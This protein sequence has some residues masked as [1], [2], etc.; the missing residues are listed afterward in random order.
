[1]VEV[2]PQYLGPLEAAAYAKGVP[3]SWIAAV[4][5]RTGW[6][7]YFEVLNTPSLRVRRLGITGLWAIL[8]D[9]IIR[10][11]DTG[12]A[13]T[14][15]T[16]PNTYCDKVYGGW[17][18]PSMIQGFPD[19]SEEVCGTC[20]PM[21]KWSAIDSYRSVS[22]NMMKAAEILANARQIS[23]TMC[24]G[25]SSIIFV[26]WMWGG[27]W[28]PWDPILGVPRCTLPPNIPNIF[29]QEIDKIIEAQKLFAEYFSEP[30]FGA[31]PVAVA[32]SANALTTSP[33]LPITFTANAAGGSK[34]YTYQWNF[35][36]G[37]VNVETTNPVIQHAFDLEG[38]YQVRCIVI[39]R[40]GE[41][42]QSEPLTITIEEGAPPPPAGTNWAL[43]GL[44]GLAGAVGLIALGK[45][46]DKR[47]QA[48]KLR[49]QASALRSQAAQLRAEG[50]HQQ[51]A[52]VEQRAT[53]LENKATQL[54]VEAAREEQEKA[55]RE[56]EKYRRV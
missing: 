22:A 30:D 6:D 43:W 49:Q 16:A 37:T 18:L 50:K 44:L 34:P 14:C 11:Q 48:R 13:G 12:M 51:A 38:T 26:R 55:R 39:D 32:I 15:F 24:G 54:E 20:G 10:V 25:D 29:V 45:K 56:A 7:P 3:R 36:D 21:F 42:G 46:G 19:G 40:V 9:V 2:P 47:E 5:E 52:A 33:G 27:Y 28:I 41:S 53:E 31:G 1:M 35:G 17:M 23:N 8:D 4:C